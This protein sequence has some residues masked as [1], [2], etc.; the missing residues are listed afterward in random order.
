MKF[1]S[2]SLFW[3]IGLLCISLNSNSQ[4]NKL[5]RKELKEVRK[6]HLAANFYVL[7]SLLNKKTFVLVADY[8]QNKYGDRIIV[9]PMLNFIKLD[10][11][12][13]I[14]QTG[15]NFSIGI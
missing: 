1:K 8:L 3:I 13:G 14:L 9:T 6:A 15:S 12:T 4:E 11:S 7:D 2:V 10:E 5:N